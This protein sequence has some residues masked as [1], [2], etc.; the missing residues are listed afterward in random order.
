MSVIA[1]GSP[2]C[3]VYIHMR[4]DQRGARDDVFDT[5]SI[6]CPGQMYLRVC[7]VEKGLTSCVLRCGSYVPITPKRSALDVGWREGMWTGQA[8]KSLDPA[9]HQ[10]CS[11][12]PQL[13]EAH[14]S[15]IRLR[16]FLA[17]FDSNQ[18]YCQSWEWIYG[19]Y[20]HFLHVHTMVTSEVMLW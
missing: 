1:E 11:P 15:H 2:W 4:Q 18:R 9:G 7:E 14:L 13:W 19:K 10:S 5:S 16:T 8:P 6:L 3:Y 20:M 17:R 12:S